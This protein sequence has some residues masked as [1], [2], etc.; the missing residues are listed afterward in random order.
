MG[1]NIYVAARF[2]QEAPT[3]TSAQQSEWRRRRAERLHIAG[4]RRAAVEI[5]RRLIH[6]AFIS[7]GQNDA[8]QTSERRHAVLLPVPGLGS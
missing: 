1:L 4:P 8:D 2:E 5:T 7:T 3:V 6:R